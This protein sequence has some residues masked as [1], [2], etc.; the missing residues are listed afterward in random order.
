M[1]VD[2]VMPK[3]GETITEGTVVQ[4][5]KKPGD[6]VKKEE[7]LLEIS[8]DKV[9]S[10]IPSPYEGVLKE[11]LAYENETVEVGKVI[12][13]IETEAAADVSGDTK[14]QPADEEIRISSVSAAL[15]LEGPIGRR[16]ERHSRSGRF[17]SPLILN[18]SRKEGIPVEELEK[19]RG[20]GIRNRVTKKD[21]LKYIED[22]KVAP[23]PPK[24]EKSSPSVQEVA[25]RW[26]G[27]RVE[28]ITMDAIRKKIAENM[29]QSKAI[30]PHVFGVAECDFTNILNIIQKH[31]S[32]FADREG[33]KLTI[34]TFVLYAATRA[35]ID[36][37]RLNSSIEGDKII[38]K[39][40][41]NLGVAVSTDRGLIVP[42]VKN[43]DEKGFGG[44]ARATQDIVIRARERKLSIDDVQDSTFTITNYGVLGTIMGFPIINQPNV[45]ILGVGAVKKRP[46]VIE[47]PKGDVIGIRSIGFLTNVYDHRVIDGDLGERFL[48][49]V[50]QYL[51]NFNEDV[52]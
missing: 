37:P 30:A 3:L 14:A 15:P 2:I 18:I 44:L 12:A 27:K 49:R 36:F 20:T 50:V 39:H 42:V 38:E 28:I 45:A 7:T 41:I 35:L 33:T 9:D 34:N 8:T 16:N 10:E 1:K 6:Y 51:E 40:Y 22:R 19:I 4:W 48:Q 11:V 23:A 47:T 17:Y 24:D 5:M 26:K 46:V 29:V 32:S 21:I 52:I 25:D 31:K 43:A 13:R